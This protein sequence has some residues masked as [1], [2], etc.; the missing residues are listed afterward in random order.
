MEN[1]KPNLEGK[2]M[3]VACNFIHVEKFET[4]THQNPHLNENPEETATLYSIYNVTVMF[5][6]NNFADRNK[7][8]NNLVLYLMLTIFLQIRSSQRHVKTFTIDADKP[9]LFNVQVTYPTKQKITKIKAYT[10]LTDS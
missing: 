9:E 8:L 10:N 4:L 6:I 3:L 1:S 2:L 7:N 5:I